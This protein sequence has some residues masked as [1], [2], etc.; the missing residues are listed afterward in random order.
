MVRVTPPASFH[1]NGDQP[2]QLMPLPFGGTD[3]GRMGLMQELISLQQAFI[4]LQGAVI[5]ADGRSVDLGSLAQASDARRAGAIDVLTQQFQRMLT[6]APIPASQ[7][8]PAAASPSNATTTPTSPAPAGAPSPF[9]RSRDCQINW[10]G[11]QRE[12][13]CRKCCTVLT[14]SEH[15]HGRHIRF[16][17]LR[18]NH[19]FGSRRFW[20]RLCSAGGWWPEI[21]FSEHLRSHSSSE[22]EGQGIVSPH[23]CCGECW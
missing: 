8:D 14:T 13:S 22:L 3:I 5:A 20:C 6:A 10:Y 19:A 16:E 4:E 9:C 18:D 12:L 17:Y 15:V 7:L 11:G 2:A 21:D 1:R 23:H